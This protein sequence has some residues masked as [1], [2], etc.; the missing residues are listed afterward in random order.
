MLDTAVLGPI[1]FWQFTENNGKL[2]PFCELFTYNYD[3]RQPK[4]TYQ[5]PGKNIPWSNPIRADDIGRFREIFWETDVPYYLELRT[6]TG[7][8]IRSTNQPYIPAAGEGTNVTN[9]LFYESLFINGQFRFFD[10]EEYS[11]IPDS[12][13]NL[14]KGGWSYEKNGTNTECSLTFKKYTLDNTAVDASP[15]YYLN[16]VANEPGTDE[17][18]N[19]IIF[20]IKDVRSLNNQT[21]S[22]GINLR[23][24]IGGTYPVIGQFVQHFGTGGTPSEDVITPFGSQNPT[25]T[26]AL[27]STTITVPNLSGKIRGTN[28]DDYVQ[29]RIRLPLNSIANLEIT[30]L[31]LKRG[32]ATLDYP[33]ISYEEEDSIIKALQLPDFNP[34]TDFDTDATVYSEEQA[35]D[36]L[37]LIPDDGV[38]IEKWIPAVPV[39]T[40]FLWLLETAPPGFVLAQGQSVIKAGKY[41]RLYNLTDGNNNKFGGRWGKPN[42]NL[43]ADL[44]G[45]KADLI[46]TSAGAA[47]PVAQGTTN[48][49]VKR[50]SVGFS[51]LVAGIGIVGNVLTVINFGNGV[52]APPVDSATSG[53]T[54]TPISNGT[55]S[56]PASW[57]LTA[58]AANLLTPGNYFTY[59][60]TAGNF[61]LYFVID[62]VGTAPV[63]SG[64]TGNPV[65][66][67]GT[68]TDVQVASKLYYAIIGFERSVITFTP[69]NQISPG[70]YFTFGIPGQN[71]AVFYSVG[72][73]GVGP[74]LVGYTNIRIDVDKTDTNLMTAFK[75]QDAL[76]PLLWYLPDG[77]GYFPRFW[78]DGAGVD[79]N[80]ATRTT[81]NLGGV[82]GDKPGT[83]EQDDIKSHLHGSPPGSTGGYLAGKAGG[84]AGNTT[85]GTAALQ[86]F[87][88]TDV[89]GGLE[90]RAKNFSFAL[91]IKY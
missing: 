31:Y 65:Y 45:N 61:F 78:D 71:Y 40:P 68:D 72:G 91:I 36:S 47:N 14:A 56:T 62:N 50:V 21:I 23:S 55:V 84:T 86:E 80:A 16:Y 82:T 20:T 8:L 59:R 33:Y 89:F 2:A 58:K 9:N 18:V 51:P 30:N 76:N 15:V 10:I 66:I 25:T 49:T 26:A 19:D 54:V 34:V 44:D 43:I 52:F 41:N 39:G 22:M 60:S 79:S 57:S 37:S 77:R 75:T 3:T 48:F 7:A 12:I 73:D 24:A 83:Y 17:T 53:L 63:V 81:L 90:T 69:G 42:I 70:N 13:P 88:T 67:L 5:D 85:G 1:P 64:Y 11:P 29:I 28:N 32:A 46:N 4:P 74:N 27:Y 87:N 6:Q 35:Y 38:L